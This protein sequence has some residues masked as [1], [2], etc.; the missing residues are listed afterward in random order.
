MP[1]EHEA[2]LSLGAY[3]FAALAYSTPAADNFRYED[4]ATAALV[5]DTAIPVEWRRRGEAALAEFRR[6][7]ADLAATRVTGTPKRVA[8]GKEV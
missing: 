2:L 4:G 6:Q 5:D 3:G 7:L 1:A 8:W